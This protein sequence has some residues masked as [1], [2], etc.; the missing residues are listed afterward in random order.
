MN[1]YPFRKFKFNTGNLYPVLNNKSLYPQYSSETEKDFLN[2]AFE[3]VSFDLTYFV[4]SNST[5]AAPAFCFHIGNENIYI[6]YEILLNK[7]NKLTIDKGVIKNK[8]I[9]V[10]NGLRVSVVFDFEED[11]SFYHTELLAQGSSEIFKTK[12]KDLI[13][14]STCS[15]LG[16]TDGGKLVYLGKKYIRKIKVGNNL[17]NKT[18]I[19][20]TTV[21]K[22]HYVFKFIDHHN[23]E[24]YL[25][26]T[27]LKNIHM[28]KWFEPIE[29][30]EIRAFETLV[31]DE[32][33]ETHLTEEDIVSYY[34]SGLLYYNG[35]WGLPLEEIKFEE[36][37]FSYFKASKKTESI[38]KY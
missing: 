12:E 18:K 6:K 7:F 15:L 38:L 1:Y 27:D 24:N 9:F 21:D 13:I 14:G 8:M 4:F 25:F 32:K 23:R 35:Y 28:Y 20:V 29:A 31:S 10:A 3:N 5:Y 37:T 16:F 30:E 34:K 22:P 33:S 26:R 17:H 19:S 2:E 11:F 36:D